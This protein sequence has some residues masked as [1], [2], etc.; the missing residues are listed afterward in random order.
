[1]SSNNNRV[2]KEFGFGNVQNQRVR[3]LNKDGTFNMKRKGLPFKA[4]F[5]FYHYLLNMSWIKF[6]FLIIA[7]Y[8]L[9][10]LVFAIIYL[11]L[12][13]ENLHGVDMRS[14]RH[15][16]FDSFFFST[17]TFTTVGYGRINPT[18]LSSNIISSLEAL[19]GLMSFALITGLLYGRFSMPE[20]RLLFSERAI[21]APYKG[22]RGL[23]F[24]IANLQKSQLLGVEVNVSISVFEDKEGKRIRS[25]YNLELER[26]S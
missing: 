15:Q 16:F 1:M 23:M 3:M 26:G 25:F 18:G 9:V 8:T 10:N 6:I 13:V 17:Q 7:W 19:I 14:F 2:A 5:N 24:R 11:M 21:V 20:S 22:M 4:S 12:G